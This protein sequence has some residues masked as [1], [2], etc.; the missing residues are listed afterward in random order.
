MF[1]IRSEEKT[2][3]KI[4]IGKQSFGDEDKF[5]WTY[6]VIQYEI[7]DGRIMHGSTCTDYSRLQSSYKDC[8][9][10]ALQSYLI[11]KFGCILPFASLQTKDRSKFFCKEGKNVFNQDKDKMIRKLVDWFVTEKDGGYLH[12]CLPPCTIYKVKILETETFINAAEQAT[13]DFFFEDF[14]D[15]Y[16]E[17][18]SYDIFSWLL[19]WEVLLVFG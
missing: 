15:V 11:E 13:L 14:I 2:G 1:L 3:D 12:Q 8:F 7:Y 16:K 19:I 18:Y 17:I 4:T 9:L 6:A 5:D 10:E